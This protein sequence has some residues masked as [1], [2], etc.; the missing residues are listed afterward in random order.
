MAF[1][2]DE[3]AQ[4]ARQDQ[5]AFEEKRASTLKQAIADCANSDKERRRLNGLQFKVDMIRRKHKTP[6]GSCVAL[7]EMLMDNVYQLIN[8]DLDEIRRRTEDKAD[9]AEK[10]QVIAFDRLKKNH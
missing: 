3:W 6:L 8:L 10:C 9:G 7:S 4:L 5:A 1:N 2:F